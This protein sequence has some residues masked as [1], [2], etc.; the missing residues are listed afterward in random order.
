MLARIVLKF[1]SLSDNIET[2]GPLPVPFPPAFSLSLSLSLAQPLCW[3]IIVPIP[4]RIVAGC[5]EI[6]I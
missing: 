1:T 4:N 5:Q 6:Q 3:K 2:S